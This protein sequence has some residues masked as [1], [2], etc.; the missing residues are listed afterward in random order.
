MGSGFNAASDQWEDRDSY[1]WTAGLE[2]A[3]PIL[4]IAGDHDP[5]GDNGTSVRALAERYDAAGKGPITLRLYPG[6]RHEV[7]N[8]INRDEVT[9]DLRTWLDGV[10]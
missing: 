9:A 8:E 4:V 2:L 6:A 3:I 5:V 1:V 7:F 10:R